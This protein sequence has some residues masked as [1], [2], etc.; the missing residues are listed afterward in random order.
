V[1]LETA[2]SA[3]EIAQRVEELKKK[4]MEKK[5]IADGDSVITTF[6]SSIKPLA[7][8][9]EEYELIKETANKALSEIPNLTPPPSFGWTNPFN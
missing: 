4:N 8:D 9:A 2:F 7:H 1:K 6:D 3:Q 5:E